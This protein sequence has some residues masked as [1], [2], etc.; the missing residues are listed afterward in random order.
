MSTPRYRFV[1]YN[2]ST[3]R[4]VYPLDQNKLVF[5]EAPEGDN[6]FY[7]RKLT[8]KLVFVNQKRKGIIDFDYFYQIERAALQCEELKI[9]IFKACSEDWELWY[10]GYF[11]TPMGSFDLDNCTFSVTPNIDDRYR[12][13]FEKNKTEINILDGTTEFETNAR[14]DSNFEY[15]IARDDDPGNINFVYN[16][17][18]PTPTNSWK[19]LS[20]GTDSLGRAYKVGYREKITTQCLNGVTVVPPGSGWILLVDDCAVSNTCVYVRQP[21]AGLPI[22]NPNVVL[23]DCDGGIPSPPPERVRLDVTIVAG[24][25][26]TS[27]DIFDVEGFT[28]VCS[29]MT[30]LAEYDYEIDAPDS[31]TL[32]WAVTGS[33]SSVIGSNSDKRVTIQ[34]G[35][36]NVV[37]RCNETTIEGDLIVHRINVTVC[38]F[39]TGCSIL[40]GKIEGPKVICKDQ[41]NIIWYIPEVYRLPVSPFGV[42]GH[43]SVW[44]SYNS[45]DTYFSDVS[46]TAYTVVLNARGAEAASY[47][48]QY[49]ALATGSCGQQFFQKSLAVEIT[50]TPRTEDIVGITGNFLAI[51]STGVRYRVPARYGS[52]FTWTVDGGTIATGQGT[53]EITVDWGA[54]PGTFEIS[55]KETI[56]C[57]CDYE[58]IADCGPDG[59]PPI[60]WCSD[61]PEVTI[62]NG[63][64]LVECI[65][66]MLEVMDCGPEEVISDFFEWNPDG[67][68]PG[69]VSGENYVY[70]ATN[71]YNNLLINQKSDVIDPQASN[72]ATKGLITW[73]E[74]MNFIREA[75]HVY[76][77]IDDDNKV[78]FEHEKYITAVI[79]IDTT[80]SRYDKYI[81]RMN[82]YT[83]LIDERPKYE[84]FSWMESLNEDFIGVPIRYEG[85][86]VNQNEDQNNKEHS[87][88]RITTDIN[89]ILV[90]PSEIAKDG[91]VVTANVLNGSDFHVI[92][93]QGLLSTNDIV[94]AP[95]SWANLHYYFHRW[96]RVLPNGF[97]NNNLTSFISF[98]PTI[99]QD[100]IYIPICC[101]DEWNPEQ[102]IKTE[103]SA[104]LGGI[105]GKVLSAEYDLTTEMMK[106]TLG[107]SYA[108]I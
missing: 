34:F 47:A 96:G 26:A 24:T 18:I 39:A 7:R 15:F 6:I 45:G 17:T 2:G 32:D 88:P 93:D 67:T 101:G 68:A 57:G 103:L 91:F 29:D 28:Q 41:Q 105:Y 84:T 46:A 60:Y 83:H 59:E 74:M 52:T 31:S 21:L 42:P 100:P 66:K 75:F 80:D 73:E 70:N 51:G 85:L 53:N 69:Y 62:P 25:S 3:V 8:S 86:C 27:A 4:Q 37:I 102:M 95:M 71:Q 78:R 23:G 55:V 61:G 48:M 20:V 56:G 108:N 87:V 35:N 44:M 97:L 54:T 81:K 72:P 49:W 65:E 89:Y 36:A 19:V 13:L 63:R 10:E 33:G 77:W 5:S 58:L 22:P 38:P 40:G 16:S 30:I 107:Y 12:C 106:L 79:G 50:N 9:K 43:P 64:L 11:T 94:N 104:Y 92:V 90:N 1:L 82:R 99:Q 76:W 14:V 98:K